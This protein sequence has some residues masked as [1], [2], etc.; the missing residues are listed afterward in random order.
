LVAWVEVVVVGR[1]VAAEDASKLAG[2]V[3]AV[4]AG[5]G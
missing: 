1:W 2:A 5:V 3:E 4:L